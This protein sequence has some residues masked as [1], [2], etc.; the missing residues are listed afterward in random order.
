MCKA[1]VDINARLAMWELYT[2]SLLHDQ[3]S[4][5]ATLLKCGKVIDTLKCNV[6]IEGISLILLA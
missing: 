3:S 6:I 5:M 1:L 2:V 4:C